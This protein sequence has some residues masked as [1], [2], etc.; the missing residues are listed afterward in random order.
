MDN[1]TYISPYKIKK[2]F[3]ISSNTLRV[4]AE[5][6]K[7]RCIRVNQVGKRIYNIEDLERIFSTNVSEKKTYCY[8]RV[9]SD[10]QKK[11]LDRQIEI[12]KMAYPTSEIIKDIGSGI[13]FKRKGFNTLLEKIYS[14]DIKRVVVTYKDRL[15]RF[16]SEICEWIFKKHNV[17]FVVLNKLSNNSTESSTNELAED[18]LAI[19]TVF[20][21]RNNGNRSA[22]YKKQKKEKEQEKEVEERSIYGDKI[23]NI[24]NI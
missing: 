6:G 5:K 9:S 7:I 19:T 8:A 3:D 18:L 17:E 24:P 22:N 23:E 16:G 15:C 13:N 14:G 2:K 21:A 12:L 11:D 10:H 1:A 20:V 4:W